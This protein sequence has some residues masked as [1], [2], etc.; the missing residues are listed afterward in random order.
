M[1]QAKHGH[2][3][4]EKA[5]RIGRRAGEL[6]LLSERLDAAMAARAKHHSVSRTVIAREP[7][8]NQVVIFE[9]AGVLAT[10]Q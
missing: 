3:R 4:S 5:H 2:E 8:G 1:A 6:E 7:V 9:V 10:G